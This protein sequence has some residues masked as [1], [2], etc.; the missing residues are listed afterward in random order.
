MAKEV[1]GMTEAT[2]P[3][4]YESADTVRAM[5]GDDTISAEEIDAVARRLGWPLND[6]HPFMVAERVR[7]PL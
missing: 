6:P 7:R 1:G 5:L 3:E 2:E 4:H